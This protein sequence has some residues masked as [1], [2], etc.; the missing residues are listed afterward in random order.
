MVDVGK[1][2]EQFTKAIGDWDVVAGTGT[3]AATPSSSITATDLQ[4]THPFE[5]IERAINATTGEGPPALL[6]GACL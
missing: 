2:R 4:F 1:L 3:T 5:R 6:L